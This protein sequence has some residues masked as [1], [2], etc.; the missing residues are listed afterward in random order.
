LYGPY[1]SSRYTNGSMGTDY[2]FT[3]QRADSATSLDYYNARYYDP[4]VGQFGSADSM[5]DGQN[6]FGYVSGNPTTYTDPSGH[7]SPTGKEWGQGPSLSCGWF[8][9]IFPPNTVDTVIP[10]PPQGT[11]AATTVAAAAAAAAAAAETAHLQSGTHDPDLDFKYGND[12]DLR[13]G[14]PVIEQRTLFDPSPTPGP[15]SSDGGGGSRHTTST[16]GGMCGDDSPQYLYHYTDFWNISSIR[17]NGLMPSI[18]DPANPHSDANFGNGVYLT[19]LTPAEAGTGTQYQMGRAVWNTPRWFP[20]NAAPYPDLVGVQID[21]RGLP[22]QR[23]APLFSTTYG[24]RS[25]YRIPTDAPVDVS[26][27][28]TCIEHVVFNTRNSREN[29]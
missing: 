17:D 14:R 4:V 10:D 8:C 20:R 3:G 26:D 23:E 1:G 11:A 2:G 9:I 18:K 28:I 29:S 6:R 5:L 24:E 25:I 16:G 21:V 15:G 7:V 13:P 27:R 12:R 19:D 22:V